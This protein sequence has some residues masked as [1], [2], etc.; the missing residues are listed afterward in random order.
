MHIFVGD[1]FLNRINF[2]GARNLV[3]YWLKNGTFVDAHAAAAWFAKQSGIESARGIFFFGQREGLKT[4]FFEAVEQIPGSIDYYFQGISS[5][6]GVYSVYKGARQ[7]LGLGKIPHMPKL[8]C[9]QEETCNPMVRAWDAGAEKVGP[10]HII[11]Y[12]RGLSKSTLRGDP[13][14]PYP[15]IRGVVK[16]T[17]GIMVTA[18]QDEMRAARKQVLEL[19]GLDICH[20]SSMTVVAAKNLAAS[21]WLDRDARVMLNITGADR[22]GELY[23]DPDFV[24]EKDGDGWRITPAGNADR[25]GCLDKVMRVLSGTIDLRPDAEI[26]TETKLAA[27]GLGMDSAALKRF[28][29]ALGGEFDVA[30]GDAEFNE[31]NFETVGTVADMFRR[32]L[33]R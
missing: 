5:A 4:A 17:D 8:V 27:G 26:D 14:V 21:G 16:D 32:L 15:Y 11:R 31:S 25:E 19:E 2:V 30:L 28:A 13:T 29:N 24:V 20:T 12:P 9:V 18:K 22:K 10:E 6:L 1:E 23:P 3:V 33:S 7:Y